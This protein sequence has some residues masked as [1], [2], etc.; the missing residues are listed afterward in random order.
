MKK[1]VILLAGLLMANTS[2]AYVAGA[3]DGI[4]DKNAIAIIGFWPTTTTAFPTMLLLESGETVSIA[5]KLPELEAE[6][7]AGPESYY[8]LRALAKQ[9]SQDPKYNGDTEKALADVIAQVKALSEFQ[10]NSSS[11]KY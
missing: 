11:G 3:F 10:N 2:Q 5:D 8:Y 6:I 1:R 9:V 4:S 7:N